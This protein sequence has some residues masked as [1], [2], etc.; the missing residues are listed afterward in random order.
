M[1]MT[2]GEALNIV[3]NLPKLL[4]EKIPIDKAYQLGE[5]V[6][7]LNDKL[8]AFET[9]RFK[10]I[11]KYGEKD[12]NGKLVDN[13]GQYKITDTKAF[14]E[15]YDKIASKEIEIDHEVISIKSLGDVGMTTRDM[16]PL[17]TLFKKEGK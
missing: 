10:L 6:V 7:Q 12:E 1:K 5:T 14:G 16:M 13:D 2:I 8:R 15:E 17:R 4:D 3:Q 9:V 11:E